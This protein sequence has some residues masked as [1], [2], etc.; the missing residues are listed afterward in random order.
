MNKADRQ[1]FTQPDR[2]TDRQRQT[3]R[4]TMLDHRCAVSNQVGFMLSQGCYIVPVLL[5]A[6]WPTSQTGICAR[7]AD[8]LIGRR[9]WQLQYGTAGQ[10]A[11]VRQCSQLPSWLL[12]V[13]RCHRGPGAF[14]QRLWP[15]A[16]S[17]GVFDTALR[18][19]RRGLTKGVTLRQP[20]LR[21]EGS[22][23]LTV[24]GGPRACAP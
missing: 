15:H 2:Q 8:S 17:T 24:D 20:C 7:S 10:L 18:G 23:P 9:G 3:R 13:R 1:T 6:S 14:L 5:L 12:W 4:P 11:H 16:F 21:P 19:V 22:K